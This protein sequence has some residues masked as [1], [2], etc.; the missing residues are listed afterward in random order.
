MGF[1]GRAALVAMVLG[2]EGCSLGRMACTA[3]FR[4]APAASGAEAHEPRKY[5]P[6]DP[7]LNRILGINRSPVAV[8]R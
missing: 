4:L 8:V 2:G 3:N 7:P 1:G 5:L 6:L